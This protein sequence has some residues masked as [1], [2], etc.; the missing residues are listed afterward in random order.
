MKDRVMKWLHQECS[1]LIII[2]IIKFYLGY[3]E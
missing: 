1:E 3:F 2:I